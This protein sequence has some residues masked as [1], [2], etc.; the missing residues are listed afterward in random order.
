MHSGPGRCRNGR[1]T[2][3]DALA[4]RL[5]GKP[6]VFHEKSSRR[7]FMFAAGLGAGSMLIGKRA[8]AQAP[9]DQ[10]RIA[11]VGCS[12][13][14]APYI[15][16]V[17]GP[18]YGAACPC[19]ADVDATR[20]EAAKRTF[21]NATYYV[22]YRQMFDKQAKDI[23]AVMINV[24]D[25][26]HYPLTA[27]AMQLGKHV[28]TQ[29]PL[30]HTVWEARQL[31]MAADKYKVVTQMGNQGHA[32]EGNRLTFEYIRSGMLGDIREAHVWT[33]RPLWPQG[34]TMRADGDAII[35]ACK[36][37]VGLSGD[38]VWPQPLTRPTGE[39]GVPSSLNWDCWLGPAPVRPYRQNVYHPI[40]WRGWRDFGT[41]ALGD[42]GAHLIDGIF[43]AM[44]AKAPVAV[45]PITSMAQP[46][47]SETYA[48]ATVMKWEF[49]ANDWRPGFAMYWH[50]RGLKPAIPPDLEIGRTL[51][52]TGYLIYGSKATLVVAGDLGDD[53]RIV[54][55]A[56][57]RELGK[58]PQMLERSPGHIEEWLAACKG[59][60]PL[61][62]P[63]S[64]FAYAGPLTE[65]ILLGNIATRVQR[66]I[67]WDSAKLM[68]TNLPAA[69][70]FISKEYRDG[71]KF[72]I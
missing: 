63:K 57:S 11:F 8:R 67:E 65:T 48:G 43:W 40:L 45:E 34:N 5:E 38:K 70:Q 26:H 25:H 50:E 44:D 72:T 27:I 56:R 60:K 66:R 24:P 30:T 69:N 58:P 3:V 68:I 61:D 17:L 9:Q 49:A 14:I 64:N 46:L 41:G 32:N 4:E 62:F 71:W 16:S 39:D 37:E 23:D 33:N 47:D 21:P 15:I 20:I 52:E 12:G 2:R 6:I 51:P 36:P 19:I 10:L 59:E 18:E 31:T 13:L 22:D 35:D 29:K 55:V 54:P 53:P 42:E 1:H 7:T 28:Y